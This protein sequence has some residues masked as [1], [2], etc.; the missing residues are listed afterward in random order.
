MP[1]KSIQLLIAWGGALLGSWLLVYAG[2]TN[3]VLPQNPLLVWALVLVLPTLTTLW[4]V[5]R[6]RAT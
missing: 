6:E 3:L 1:S 2:S 5:A 4:I